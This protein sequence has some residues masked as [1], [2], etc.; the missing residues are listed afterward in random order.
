MQVI[1]V[2]DDST[3]LVQAVPPKVT[4]TPLKN[5]VPKIVIWFPPFNTPAAGQILVMVGL[6]ITTFPEEG[7]EGGVNPKYPLIEQDV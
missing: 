4:S 7:V 5:P 1:A 2:E 3:K 6:S